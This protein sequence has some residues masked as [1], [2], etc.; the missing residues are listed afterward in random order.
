MKVFGKIHGNHR[1]LKCV[2]KRCYQ[3]KRN[4]IKRVYY[5]LNQLR[6]SQLSNVFPIIY[7]IRF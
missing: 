4:V 1:R 6:Y 3:H 7:I 5:I 2:P